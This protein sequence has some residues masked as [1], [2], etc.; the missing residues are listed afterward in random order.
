M[1]PAG[2]SEAVSTTSPTVIDAPSGS[3]S[4]IPTS[5]SAVA[6]GIRW[7]SEN[8]MPAG[9]IPRCASAGNS[10]PKVES[11]SAGICSSG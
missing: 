1:V 2:S 7:C 8:G 9:A 4:G 5:T 10:A 6:S 3:A 11:K